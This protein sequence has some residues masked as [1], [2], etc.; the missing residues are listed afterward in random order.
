MRIIIRDYLTINEIYNNM[1]EECS[2]HYYEFDTIWLFSQAEHI[3]RDFAQSGYVVSFD[4]AA[5]QL[6]I[7]ARLVNPP[8]MTSGPSIV[9]FDMM[10]YLKFA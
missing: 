8:T 10:D 2:S 7:R 4:E 6:G 1:I 5:K 9:F 3:K